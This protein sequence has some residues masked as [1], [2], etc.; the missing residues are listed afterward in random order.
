VTLRESMRSKRCLFD[1]TAG[2]NPAEG[3]VVGVLCFFLCCAFSGLCDE[4]ITR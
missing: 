3:V 2:S 4:L 1:E